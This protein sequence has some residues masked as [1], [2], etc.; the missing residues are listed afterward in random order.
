M[1][2]LGEQISSAEDLKLSTISPGD[3]PFIKKR[4]H[5]LERQFLIKADDYNF[6][7]HDSFINCA[8]PFKSEMG[9]FSKSS[10]K[11]KGK[12]KDSHLDIVVQFLISSGQLTK[13]EISIYFK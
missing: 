5:L 2:G 11:Y 10:F 7:S 3:N 12:L 13:E 6:L 9:M 1:V 4:Q 8:Q